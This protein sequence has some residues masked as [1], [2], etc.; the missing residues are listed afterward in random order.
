MIRS[1]AVVAAVLAVAPA[2]AAQPAK[3][4]LSAY[5]RCLAGP[6]ARAQAGAIA[7]VDA[8][9]RRQDAALE[10][11][12]QAVL[13]DM[14]DLEKD[15]DPP[16]A[17]ASDPVR[18]AQRAWAAFRD[19]DC[20]LA[21]SPTW[22]ARAELDARQCVLENT[23]DRA[24][25]LA[26]EAN[27]SAEPP[28]GAVIAPPSPCEKR[29]HT[30]RD[31]GVCALND[32]ARS[33]ARLNRTYKA[34]LAQLVPGDKDTLRAAQRLWIAYR[35]AACDRYMDDRLW[36]R[37]GGYQATTCADAMTSARAD[38]LEAFFKSHGPRAA[39]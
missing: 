38:Q 34:L 31:M 3:A 20:R 16:E 9:I 24:E 4:P 5:D 19:A 10:R 28:P 32:L 26:A 35:D 15:R 37:D 30:A 11:D 17:I 1:L 14:I 2:Q 39:R 7:C 6:A 33:D 27:P 12:Y 36:G 8:E 13:K 22:G 23:I 21:A 25:S 29:A 18:A